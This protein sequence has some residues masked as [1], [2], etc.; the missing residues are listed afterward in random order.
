[1]PKSWFNNGFKYIFACVDVF[2][3]KA[4]M[5]PLKDREQTTTTKAF[6]KIKKGE[7]KILADYEAKR[8]K[9]INADEFRPF[10]GNTFQTQMKDSTDNTIMANVDG[11]V[12][13]KF[14]HKV[15]Q[16]TQNGS[17]VGSGENEVE[18]SIL[19]SIPGRVMWRDVGIQYAEDNL[20]ERRNYKTSDYIGHLDGDVNSSLYY[21][22]GED[23]YTDKAGKMM[24]EYSKTSLVNDVAHVYKGGSWRDRAY[25]M[26]PGSRRFLD[27][28]QALAYLGFRCAMTR[29]GSP[30]GLGK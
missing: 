19:V 21:E 8:G 6:E 2:S 17:N 13:K 24:Y 15:A 29:V 7:A 11:P 14:K 28:R 4:D 26:N 12:F 3:K 1:M 9:V 25:W 30:T 23:A 22:Q 18:D 5:I 10:R 16:P 27:Q 20:D